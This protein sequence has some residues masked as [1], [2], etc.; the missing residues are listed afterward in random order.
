VTIGRRGRVVA[1]ALGLT[2]ALGAA[3]GCGGHVSRGELHALRDDPLARYVPPGGRVVRTDA[4]DQRS[5][6]L[7]GKPTPA[8]LRRLIALPPGGGDAALRDAAAAARAAGWSLGRP[9]PGLGTTGH[10]RMATGDGTLSLSLLTDPGAI[11]GD[12]PPPVLSIA[13]EHSR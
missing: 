5:G 13:L 1:L 8:T 9:V 3:V 11:P 7:F 4:D 10:R 2:A 6:G 12:T